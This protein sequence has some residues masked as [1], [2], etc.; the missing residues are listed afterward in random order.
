M[1]WMMDDCNGDA[2]FESLILPRWDDFRETRV[3][4]W[5]LEGRSA[6]TRERAWSDPVMDGN[7]KRHA[8]TLYLHVHICKHILFLVASGADDKD[9][10]TSAKL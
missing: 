8:N 9:S 6:T 3:L 2:F 1:P 7:W 5:L 4:F 10:M